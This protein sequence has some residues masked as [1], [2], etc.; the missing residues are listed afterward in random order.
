MLI[1]SENLARVV[2]KALLD[3]EFK[4]KLVVNPRSILQANGVDVP[5]NLSIRVQEG[6]KSGTM[7][8]PTEYVI[9]IPSKNQELSYEAAEAPENPVNSA[10]SYKQDICAGFYQQDNS[11]KYYTQD[12]S[13]MSY[14]Q[15]ISNN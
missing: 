2:A 8:T 15:D 14:K 13:A 1:E 5:E 11:A 3:R 7:T 12:I 6:N 10:M 9:S 4:N